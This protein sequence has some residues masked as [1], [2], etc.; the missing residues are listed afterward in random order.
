[1]LQLGKYPSGQIHGDWSDTIKNEFRTWIGKYPK[2][3]T[4]TQQE[5]ENYLS[6]EGH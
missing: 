3:L 2:K 1:M 4:V 5:I 6:K